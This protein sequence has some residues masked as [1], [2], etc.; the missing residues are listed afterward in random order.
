MIAQRIVSIAAWR[1]G[2]DRAWLSR[3]VVGGLTAGA[4][5][6]AQAMAYATVA[7]LP[8]QVGLYTCMVPM[9]VYAL[10]G[11]SRTL[12]VSTMSTVAI[13]TASTLLAADVAASSH[14]P[15]RALAM[16]TLVVGAI[17]LVAR[18]LRLGGRAD[19]QH[20]R[21]HADRDQVWRVSP[22]PRASP[23]LLAVPGN[24]SADNATALGR[25]P[26]TVVHEFAELEHELGRRGVTLWIVALPPNAL[27]LAKQTPR[28]RELVQANRLYP[29]ALAAV[30]A[31]RGG[32]TGA[33][34]A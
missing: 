5:V 32:R 16:L 18:V 12:S 26:L 19:R 28:W 6:I 31:F 20:L 4:V 1:R 25:V 33:P 14:D 11:G 9:A 30:S 29:T 15:T 22:S 21:G 2:Y 3:D 23:K 24:P 27:E 17:L 8:V 34:V 7:D 13:L 10:L